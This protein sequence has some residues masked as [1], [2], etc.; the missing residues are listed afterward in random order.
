MS[1]VSQTRNVARSTRHA[2]RSGAA[3]IGVLTVLLFVLAAIAVPNFA[4]SS[5]VRSLLLSVSLVGIAAVGLSLITIIGRIFALSIASMIALTTIVFAHA[6]QFGPWIAFLIAVLSGTAMGLLQGSIVGLLKADP[7]ITT[8]AFSAILLGAGQE[9]TG[10]RT[11]VG[12]G[13]TGILNQNLMGIPFQVIVF[14]AGTA[15]LGWWQRYTAPGRR[16]TLIGSNERAAWLSGLRAG[17]HVLLS[18]LIFGTMVGTSG[19]LLAAQSGEGNVLLGGTFGFDVI[20][21]VVVGGVVIIG[22]A[23][24]PANAAIG[25]IF[26]GLL[27]NILALMGLAY[28]NQLLVKGVL[29]LL[30]VVLMGI[31][32][33]S[34]RPR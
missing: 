29:V 33:R 4:S 12:S 3:V 5:N 14:L 17:P 15:I 25:A 20:I 9:W 22:G 32:E 18:F 21:A 31:S 16:I 28:Q 19:A 26:V 24:N 2:V 13:G 34:R 6:L 11:V 8:I 7:I 10:G 1:A 23:G 27:G 30:A